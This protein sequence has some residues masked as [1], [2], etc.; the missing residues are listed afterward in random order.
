[1]RN[2]A[3]DGRLAILAG[4]TTCEEVLRVAP[5]SR[6][7]AQ[8]TFAYTALDV[9]GSK[10]SARWTPAKRRGHCAARIEGRF[11]ID[12]REEK[13]SACSANTEGSTQT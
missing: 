1:M 2:A 6:L 12:I 13:Q 8:L 11:V 4:K 3:G 9:A 5:G 7:M 10:K